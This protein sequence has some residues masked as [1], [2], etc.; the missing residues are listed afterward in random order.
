M[1]YFNN[2][3]KLASKFRTKV[4][5]EMSQT[6]TTELFF[7]NV[8]NQKQFSNELQNPSGAMAQFL[9]KAYEKLNKP[10][11]FSLKIDAQPKSSA[12]WLFSVNPPTLTAQVKQIA[13]AEFKKIMHQSMQERLSSAISGAKSGGGS[14]L[15]DV[16]SLDL[17]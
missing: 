6:G 1:S 7:D 12:S 4:A 17:E 16:A 11:S 10:I 8:Q 2:I 14:G 5:I 9:T 3:K 13:D 15:L